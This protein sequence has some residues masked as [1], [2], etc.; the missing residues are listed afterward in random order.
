VAGAAGEVLLQQRDGFEPGI[1]L[2]GLDGERAVAGEVA[3]DFFGVGCQA[4]D[5]RPEC[6]DSRVVG[7]GW[8]APEA[9]SSLTP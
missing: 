9:P 7:C 4:T 2:Q 8:G 5:C 3:D 1:A 6:T